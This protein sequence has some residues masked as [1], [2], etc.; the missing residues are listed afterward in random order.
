[1]ASY[2]ANGFPADR[3]DFVD[4]DAFDWLPRFQRRGQHFDLVIVAPPPSRSQGR[5]RHDVERDWPALAQQAAAVV[6]P[7][8]HLLA[9]S[10]Q[11]RLT[12]RG[13]KELVMAGVTAVNRPAAEVAYW[14]D[15][16]LDFPPA[17]GEE[18]VL[19]ALLLSIE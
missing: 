18:G 10:R 2:G 1:M 11:P 14:R 12:R 4:G 16:A 19:K 3:Y 7:G 6:A 9:C 8:G 13:F 5:G 15:P 17:P